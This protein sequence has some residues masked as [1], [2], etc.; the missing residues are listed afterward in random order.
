MGKLQLILAVV[1]LLAL[2]TSGFAKSMGNFKSYK[3]VT[4]KE[5]LI[6]TTNGSKVLISAYNNYAIQISSL[7]NTEKVALTSPKAICERADLSGSIYVEELDDMMQITTT[8]DDGLVI[9]I[10]KNPLR[11]T[12]INKLHSSILF[13]EAT[14]VKFGSKSNNINFSV[15]D[16]EELKLVSRKNHQ[17]N[18]LAINN[19]DVINVDKV[20][21]FLYPENEICLVSSK[22]YA[23]VF[24]SKLQH[25]INY[26]KSEKVKV[27]VMGSEI[28]QF[29]F[30]LIYGPQQPELI[31]KYAFHMT[32]QDN[33]VSLNQ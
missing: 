31:D 7:N 16:D 8:I 15:G 13:E 27:S 5:V 28:N 2:N 20:N 18:T 14:A 32:P 22:G 1:V 33:Q 24:D 6:E 26:S 29:N 23:I 21:E 9:K 30:L 12:Y 10:E 17:S 11:F 4:D 3:Q 25:E 19:G